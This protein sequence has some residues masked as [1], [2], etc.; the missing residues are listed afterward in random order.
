MMSGRPSI[1][2]IQDVKTK[3]E[4]VNCLGIYQLTWVPKVIS[5]DMGWVH[6]VRRHETAILG[7]QTSCVP[8]TFLCQV[9]EKEH[10]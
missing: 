9:R 8:K 3:S 10:D 7:V 5:Y 2:I 6:R 4:N 1:Y